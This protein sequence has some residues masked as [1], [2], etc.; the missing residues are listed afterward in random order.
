MNE[1]GFPL[2]FAIIIGSVVLSV[3]ALVAIIVARV[4][5]GA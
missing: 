3:F 2:S 1:G 5:L 4:V